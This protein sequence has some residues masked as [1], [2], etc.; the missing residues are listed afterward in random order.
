MHKYSRSSSSG[1]T[2]VMRDPEVEEDNQMIVMTAQLQTT[3][4]YWD[5]SQHLAPITY[6][7]HNTKT[8]KQAMMLPHTLVSGP[9]TYWGLE[10]GN[11][12]N[13]S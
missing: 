11:I 7:I 4:L 1:L 3:G 10:Q 6:H 8:N 9:C 5:C 13:L 12:Y 2:L